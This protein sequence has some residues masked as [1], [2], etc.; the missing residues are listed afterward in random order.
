ML[1]F[2]GLI[3]TGSVSAQQDGLPLGSFT[4]FPTLGLSYGH[5]DNILYTNSDID[6]ISSNYTIFSPGIRLETEGEKTDFMAQY[7]YNRTSF[8]SNSK[9][10]V[11]MHHLSASLGHNPSNRSRVSLTGEYFNGSDRVGTAN[12]QG[13]LIDLGL[14]PDE[15]HS[16]GLVAKGHYG[17]VGAKGSIDLEVG[18]INRR[19]DNNREFTAT[20]DRDTR[21]FGVTYGHQVTAK[22]NYL[23]QVKHSDIDYDIATLDNTETRVMF[24]AEWSATGKTSARA[25]V[26][27]LEKNFDDPIHEDFSGLALEVGATY[28]IKTYST[29]D[30]T[31]TRETDETNGNGSYVVRNS[32]DMGWTHFWKDRFSTTANIGISDED[33]KEHPR[34]DRTKYYGVSAKYQFSDWLMSGLG[35][36]HYDRN[37]S[38]NDFSYEDNSWLL[39]LEL[40]K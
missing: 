21:Y 12:Q 7:D 3:F 35:F 28:N 6:E 18:G 5:S 29:L 27:Y 17:G 39:T 13:G 25:L 38:V 36:K 32:A 4:V 8:D 33:Y 30:M 9:Y 2:M 37:S 20:R 34:D 26:G 14:D 24:G 23:V 16:V 22:T 15:W 31:L 19:Y 40:S 10:D 1:G 11:E